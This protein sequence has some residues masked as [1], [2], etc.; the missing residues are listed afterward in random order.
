MSDA[1]AIQDG[2]S[3]KTQAF[4]DP[5]FRGS[6]S[7]YERDSLFFNV[8]GPKFFDTGHAFDLDF[9]DDGRAVAPIDVDGDG[10]LDLALL[11]LQGLRMLENRT[12]A[13]KF[14]RIKLEAAKGDPQAIGARVALKAGGVTQLDFVKATTGF[15]T[16]CLLD[17][18]FGLGAAEKI[19]QVE[20]RWRDGTVETHKDLPVDRRIVIKQGAAPR[21]EPL[22]RWTA[23]PRVEGRI[24]APAGV[25][26]VVKDGGATLVY[27]PE[28]RLRRAFYRPVGEEEIAATVNHLGKG[29]FHADLTSIATHHMARNELDVA[30]NSLARAIEMDPSFPMAHFY[31]GILRGMQNRH[32]EAVAS[33][34]KAILLDSY[35]RQARHNLGIALYKARKL[36]EAAEAL[37]E[38]VGLA[39]GA[40]TR[41]VLGQVLAESG[42]LEDAVAEIQRAVELDAKRAEAYGDLGKILIALGRVKEAEANL[43][44]ALELKPGLA[45]AQANLRK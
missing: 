12:P 39:D 33:F 42:K 25:T 9:D 4:Q 30:E 1:L 20:I 2:L 43:K 35:H 14:A 11:S 28:G 40:E 18:H 29:K 31:L 45:E 21:A 36:S 41:H 17:L 22:P 5:Q 38:T 13:R 37:R 23:P 34:R 44:K 24:K 8:P 7:G 6:W 10:D 15:G 3:F 32:T 16:Q 26:G 27:D 19:D